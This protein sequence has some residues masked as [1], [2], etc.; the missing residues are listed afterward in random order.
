MHAVGKG[1][2]EILAH[3]QANIRAHKVI[4]PVNVTSEPTRSF[5]LWCNHSLFLNYVGALGGGSDE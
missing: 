4:Q 1:V 5:N 2:E 3:V